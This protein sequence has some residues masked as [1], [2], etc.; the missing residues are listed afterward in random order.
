MFE[1][2]VTHYDRYPNAV[3]NVLAFVSLRDSRTYQ[4]YVTDPGGTRRL[5]TDLNA[6]HPHVSP[7]GRWVAFDSPDASTPN[8]QRDLWL[9]RT[10][11]TGLRKLTDSATDEIWPTFSPDGGSV[12]FSGNADGRWQIYR[13]PLD[14]QPERVTN[15]LVG[16]AWQPSWN[17]STDPD[18]RDLIAYTLDGD[19]N[20]ATEGDQTI[21]ITSGGNGLPLLVGSRVGWQS[22]WPVWLPGG[23]DLLFLSLNK[24]C[25]CPGDPEPR[26]AVDLVYRVSAPT[27]GDPVLLLEEDRCVDSPAWLDGG[28]VVARTTARTRN[29]AT[30]QDI[31]PDGADPRDL[32][33][34]VLTEDPAALT[35]S[36]RLFNPNPG[37][38]P[39]TQRQSYSPDG[40]RIAV[41]RFETIE[42]R[43]SQRV[44]ITDA[45]GLNGAPMPLADRKVGDWETDAAWSPDGTLVAVARRSPGAP[46]REGGPSRVVIVRVDT[47]EVVARLRNPDP[48][49]D[50]D[51]GQPAWSPDG[52]VLAFSRGTVAGGPQG[53]PRTHH[54]WT[55]RAEG[56]DQQ[57]DISATV[58]GFACD[59]TDDSPAFSPDGRTLVFNREND[60]LLRVTLSDNRCEVLLPEGQN[61]CSGALTDPNGPPQPRDVSFSP[62]GSKLVMTKRT[63]YDPNSPESMAILDLDTRRLTRLAG[64]LPGR[65]KEPTWQLL[66]DLGL[67]A[68]PVAPRAT[69]GVDTSVT[70]TVTNRGP[71]PS[72]GTEL[73]VSV[74]PG[75]TLIRMRG[76]CSSNG[77]RCDIGLLPPNTTVQVTA[78]LTPTEP[79]THPLDWTVTSTVLDTEPN[80]NGG[81]TLVPVDVPA[82]PTTTTTTTPPA[83]PTSPAPP[84]LPGP[85][86]PPPAS[87]GVA[88]VAQPN[89]S[90]VGGSTTITYT[91]RNRGASTAT[92]LRL[93]LGLPRRVPVASVPP[94]CVRNSCALPD[95]APGASL[96]VQVLLRPDAA[97]VADVTGQLRTTGTDADSGDNRARTRLRILL[98][99]IVAVPPIGKPGFVTSVRGVDFPPGA[100]VRLTWT[101]GITASA[102]PTTPRADG[103][104]TAQ[105]LILTKDQT[106]PRVITASG[107]GFGPVTTPFLV[108]TGMIAPPGVVARR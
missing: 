72:P 35:D 16:A 9:V 106:G 44:W 49:A 95:L 34:E 81:T 21:R 90:Y 87:P 38:D 20:E 50:Q 75:L 5:T 26:G 102:A 32:G 58:C 62:D 56:L 19:A 6:L 85:Q 3:G 29:V 55:A 86:P 101:P 104:F 107:P 100:P 70:V 93:D 15:L 10:D 30:M 61:S 96:T 73:Q 43:R 8:G 33:V 68:P 17:P 77:P 36:N 94:A 89:P 97:L 76:A 88:V 60:G 78:D 27:A 31:R 82:P 79:G 1:G 51:D 39:W 59:T 105:L 83:P 2:S 22:R 23:A 37:F 25:G 103:T 98:P 108:V 12:A 40:R 47:G 24:V 84:P 63:T 57:R 48:N 92:G 11:G 53:Q 69:V 52:R 67:D 45:D 64:G 54:V 99:K 46:N 41:S 4:V 28:L 66:V 80:D 18:K 74:P 13:M 65:Q 7:D 14:G 42:G 71:G 91:V